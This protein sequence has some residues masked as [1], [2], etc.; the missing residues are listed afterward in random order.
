MI[1]ACSLSH[2]PVQGRKNDLHFQETKQRKI[3]RREE[4]TEGAAMPVPIELTKEYGYVVLVLVAYAFLNFWMSFQVGKARRKYKVFYPTMY[5][6]GSENKDAKLFNCVQRGHQNSL[7]V[8]PLFFA[9]LLLGGLQHPAAA[10][11]LGALYTVARFFYFT[12]YATGAPRNRMKIGVPLSILAGVGLIVCA[13]SF[14]I[15][16]VVRE[17]L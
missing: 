2:S 4:K 7:E 3:T 17:T 1:L 5:A 16:L 12:G 10:A 9:M 6:V 11:G 13:A 8:M 14:G 15:N